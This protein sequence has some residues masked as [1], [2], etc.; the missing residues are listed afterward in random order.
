MEHGFL[1]GS[2]DRKDS[3]TM[4][5]RAISATTANVG[6]TVEPAV[7]V[8]ESCQ[9]QGAMYPKEA[10][11]RG[12]FAGRGDFEEGAVVK[13]ASICGH[14]IERT[15]DIDKARIRACAAA[16]RKVIEDVVRTTR[17]VF[18]GRETSRRWS[19]RS[20]IST[21]APRQ[22]LQRPRRCQV[23]NSENPNVSYPA[24]LLSEERHP[25]E[26]LDALK[27]RRGADPL[28]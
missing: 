16:P 14:A 21:A 23:R 12:F 20:A 9:R 17:A 26:P 11:Q 15:V 3:P 1:S 6:C 13:G 8:S 18:H 7:Y 28:S 25:S 10:V 4:V 24:L 22:A 27:C 5:A 19:K 2:C